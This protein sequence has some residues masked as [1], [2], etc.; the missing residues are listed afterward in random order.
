M[1]RRNAVAAWV[2]FAVAVGGLAGGARAYPGG[3]PA[4][5]TDVAPFCAGCHA[6]R[7]ESQLAGLPAA[8]VAKELPEAKHLALIRAGEGGYEAL[9]E[10]ERRRLAE[11]VAAVDRAATV[12]LEAPSEVAAG[13]VFEVTVRTRGGA[14][15]VVG[16]ALVDG[17]H[18]YLARPAASAGWQVEGEPE[19]RVEGGEVQREWLHRRPEALGRNLSF[20]NITGVEG[21]AETGRYTATRTVFRLRAPSR[22]GSY[23]LAAVFFYGTEKATPLG[24]VEDPIR[25][26]QVRGG[27]LGHSGRILFT[28]VTRIE[29]R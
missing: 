14:G 11:L 29:V 16:V 7:Q 28:D 20:V 12:S 3:T 1:R 17:G 18:R 22:P 21:D 15:P 8:R 27:F 19:P 2:S 6:S 10:A 26:R 23:P 4:Y 13:A 9:S 24:Y 25:G 5:Q